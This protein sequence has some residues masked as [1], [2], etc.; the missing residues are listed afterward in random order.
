MNKCQRK[1]IKSKNEKARDLVRDYSLSGRDFQFVH[2]N[3][4]QFKCGRCRPAGLKVRGQILES[5][6]KVKQ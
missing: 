1:L 2:I 3:V 6:P 4:K 5:K